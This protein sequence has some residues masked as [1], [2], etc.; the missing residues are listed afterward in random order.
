MLCEYLLYYPGISGD[1]T[2]PEGVEMDNTLAALP[3]AYS[4]GEGVQAL[5]VAQGSYTGGAQYFITYTNQDGVSG[6]ISQTCTTNTFG[7]YGSLLSSG[8]GAS[9][10]GPFIPLQLGDTGIRSVQKITWL[11][12]NG[13]IAALVLA[14]R[15]GVLDIREINQPSEKDFLVD[16][17]LRMPTIKNQTYIYV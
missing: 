16:M 10:F 11:S 12:A 2:E 4:D 14:R 8:V 15:A 9:Q 6:R 3:S 5:L 7:I 1:D 13:G 17:G